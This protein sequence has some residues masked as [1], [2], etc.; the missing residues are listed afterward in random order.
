MTCSSHSRT[1]LKV[2]S[3]DFEIYAAPCDM[4]DHVLI[5]CEATGCHVMQ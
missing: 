3:S 5:K 1:E 2:V 4:L